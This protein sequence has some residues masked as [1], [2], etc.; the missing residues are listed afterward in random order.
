M[1]PIRLKR[2]PRR[3]TPE[4]DGAQSG[5]AASAQANRRK[6]ACGKSGANGDVEETGRAEGTGG[7][8]PGDGHCDG[9]GGAESCAGCPA[10][11]QHQV[12]ATVTCSNCGTSTTP[13]WRRDLSGNVIC[14]ACGLYYKLHGVHRPMTMRRSVIKRRRRVATGMVQAAAA[15]AAAVVP[16]APPMTS[17]ATVGKVS[18]V[19]A[20]GQ[21]IR[22]GERDS[23]VSS[24]AM[25]LSPLV[26][27]DAVRSSMSEDYSDR[28]TGGERKQPD[29]EMAG[30]QGRHKRRR[31]VEI[32]YEGQ[33]NSNMPPS[34]EAPVYMETACVP[35][36]EDYIVP[37]RDAPYPGSIP[38]NDRPTYPSQQQQQ[39][40]HYHPVSQASNDATYINASTTAT[41]PQPLVPTSSSAPASSSPPPL[42][43]PSLAAHLSDIPA[44]PTPPLCTAPL[45]KLPP[46]SQPSSTVLLSSY[47][48][49]QHG[50]GAGYVS[51]NTA[52]NYPTSMSAS[53]Q[54]SSPSWSST[55][56]AG[57]PVGMASPSHTNS[58]LASLA[59][60]A[61]TIAQNQP[62]HTRELTGPASSYGSPQLSPR[63]HPHAPLHASAS[64]T[65]R[66]YTPSEPMRRSPPLSAL[67][68]TK[69]ATA[70]ITMD[71]LRPRVNSIASLLNM[72]SY[73]T[74]EQARLSTGRFASETVP[75]NTTP[76]SS[77]AWT[78]LSSPASSPPTNHATIDSMPFTSTMSGLSGAHEVLKA[79]ETLA[80]LHKADPMQGVR[81]TAFDMDAISV[82]TTG[83]TPDAIRRHRDALRDEAARLQTLLERTNAMLAGLDQ[84]CE[85]AHASSP[86]ASD[87]SAANTT[88]TRQLS[89]MDDH[90]RSSA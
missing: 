16:P 25:L 14:N 8:C 17:L 82:A 50:N 43:L 9:T 47:E 89:P 69:S 84:L 33:N 87:V 63:P 23:M 66:S 70:S 79:G 78:S 37:R 20:S 38:S 35:P 30:E 12:K 2:S 42:R 28:Q 58:P 46:L 41:P 21:M 54:C 7:T 61:A 64:P 80:A 32:A 45:P 76:S 24:N 22:S 60:A 10:F 62:A 88:K 29:D 85:N 1:R 74:R 90:L 72:D 86:P 73:A 13:L 57:S 34:T 48:R 5:D 55:R 71:A 18:G 31:R 4:H 36:I 11:N 40:A 68:L 65:L 27:P 75:T 26:S 81:S 3:I 6:H 52:S 19:V 53:T 59:A 15:A 67:P 39:P 77:S 83:L 44:M 49:E 51:H 56:S